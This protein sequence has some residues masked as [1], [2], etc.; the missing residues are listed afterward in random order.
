MKRQTAVKRRRLLGDFF[1]EFIKHSALNAGHAAKDLKTISAIVKTLRIRYVTPTLKS[2]SKNL[3]YATIPPHWH[4]SKDE[5]QYMR[6]A[7][8]KEWFMY[9]FAPHIQAHPT[10]DEKTRLPKR[11]KPM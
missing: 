9:G 6:A 8:V 1:E 7:T 5:L 2:L 10:H 11:L 3:Y 4:H